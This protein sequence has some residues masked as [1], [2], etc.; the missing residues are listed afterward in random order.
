MGNRS[1][2]FWNVIG[3]VGKGLSSAGE[4]IDAIEQ[5]Q[6][7]QEETNWQ[8]TLRERQLKQFAEQDAFKQKVME[9]VGSKP[10]VPVYGQPGVQGMDVTRGVN[11]QRD[12][13]YNMLRALS[14]D[15]SFLPPTQFEARDRALKTRLTE[16]QIA[17]NYAQGQR[18]AN[19]QNNVSE[20][21]V[22]WATLRNAGYSDEDIA[23]LRSGI[24]PKPKA[25]GP[26]TE[27]EVS[28]AYKDAEMAVGKD[29]W[30]KLPPPE[31]VKG[32][33]FYG[34]K[35]H[36]DRWVDIAPP[37]IADKGS[38]GFL[39]I[40]KRA[41]TYNWGENPTPSLTVS[42]ATPPTTFSEAVTQILLRPDFTPEEK[43]ALIDSAR[44]N[45]GTK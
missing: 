31:Q 8:R 24:T 44:A 15:M 14:G 35:R 11:Q 21:E 43:T 10:Q 6:L 5:R 9:A 37:P 3:G 17:E 26:L 19:P 23:K 41:P 13:G 30:V 16:S 25:E 4:T 33:N 27:T 42:P 1:R 34:R 28:T 20:W 45:F 40:G 29:Q 7:E 2:N 38:G 32:V 39:G 36:G 18:A 22:L 12:W